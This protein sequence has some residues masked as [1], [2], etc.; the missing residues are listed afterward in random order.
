MP[1]FSSSRWLAE[2]TATHQAVLEEVERLKQM[3]DAA[4][5]EIANGL[6]NAHR[7]A[8][9]GHAEYTRALGADAR[10]PDEQT[11]LWPY[12]R[13][14]IRRVLTTWLSLL[15]TVVTRVVA[16][17]G[18]RVARAAACLSLGM[19]C[20]AVVSL[21][22]NDDVGARAGQALGNVV[23]WTPFFVSAVAASLVRHVGR[24]LSGSAT[25]V[26]TFLT[27]VVEL[28][29]DG[30][31]YVALV[32]SMVLFAPSQLL[33]LLLSSCSPVFLGTFLESSSWTRAQNI[34]DADFPALFWLLA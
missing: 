18:V 11:P 28:V 34:T 17:V 29:G 15:G 10:A 31:L 12:L 32:L 13:V 20:V 3:P 19:A 33:S 30:A 14:S 2:L 27:H 7:L 22:L 8:I 16:H 24:I 23:F 21:L 5:L 4:Y 1:S 25:L 26:A 9:H 6:M